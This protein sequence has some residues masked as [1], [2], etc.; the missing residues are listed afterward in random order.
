MV[1]HEEPEGGFWLLL[2]GGAVEELLGN[3][4]EAIT[5][6]IDVLREQGR[7]PQPMWDRPSLFVACLRAAE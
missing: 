6:V 1:I 7:E 3:I 2:A 4:C 5:G